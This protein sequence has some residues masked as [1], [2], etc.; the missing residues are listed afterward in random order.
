[1]SVGQYD[2]I[3]A[4]GGAAGLMCALRAGQRG[5]RGVAG[6]RGAI[7]N[8]AELGAVIGG[9]RIVDDGVRQRM[10]DILSEVRAGRF[11]AALK[12]EEASGYPRLRAARQR[13]RE[14]AVEAARNSLEA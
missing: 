2:V 7:S 6:R 8:T 10:R 11:S 14:M 13:A 5:R 3:V 4:G 9:P 12:E 1:M